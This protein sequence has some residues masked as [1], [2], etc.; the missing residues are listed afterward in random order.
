MNRSPVPSR[1]KLR[2]SHPTVILSATK[3]CQKLK[4]ARL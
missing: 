3:K 1:N 4:R 2:P